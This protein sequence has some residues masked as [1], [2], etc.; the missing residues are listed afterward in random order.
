MDKFLVR[1]I[2]IRI[3][4]FSS[5]LCYLHR[6]SVNM[7]PAPNLAPKREVGT[8]QI[9]TTDSHDQHTAP[10]YRKDSNK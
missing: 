3:I 10:V 2:K 7:N 5:L 8:Q 6:P 9:P 1:L 4:F